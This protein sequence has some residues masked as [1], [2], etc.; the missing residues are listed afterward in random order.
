MRISR[1]T[2]AASVNTSPVSLCSAAAK[3][4]ETVSYVQSIELLLAW[5]INSIRTR[6][7]D[8]WYTDGAN[9]AITS[10]DASVEA[11]HG[12][13]LLRIRI[14]DELRVF[15]PDWLPEKL[16]ICEGS[17]VVPD[18]RDGKFNITREESS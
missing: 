10:L 5:P 16:N 12:R 14:D 13:F 2:P 15:I 17:I 7:A 9:L 1:R 8:A 18:D 3:L 4:P 11:L 6:R